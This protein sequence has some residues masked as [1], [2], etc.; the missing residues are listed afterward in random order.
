MNNRDLIA[1]ARAR[2]RRSISVAAGTEEQPTRD[3]RGHY[4]P[5]AA[6]TAG[7]EALQSIAASLLAIAQNRIGIP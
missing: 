7:V 2:L 6:I 3:S 5:G 4:Y 1:E